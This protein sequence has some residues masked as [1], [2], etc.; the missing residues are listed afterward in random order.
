MEFICWC[1]AEIDSHNCLEERSNQER[2]SWKLTPSPMLLQF[3]GCLTLR[4]FGLRHTH[5]GQIIPKTL[6]FTTT[7]SQLTVKCGSNRRSPR[8]SL[9]NRDGTL[10]V[11]KSILMSKMHDKSSLSEDREYL[12]NVTSVGNAL[13]GQQRRVLDFEYAPS[14]KWCSATHSTRYSVFGS[15]AGHI[16]VMAKFHINMSNRPF[17]DGPR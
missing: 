17:D 5:S 3:I 16:S 6:V 2:I 15:M 7:V 8:F 10:L 12:V 13:P 14:T 1:W 9:L 4:G 11:D